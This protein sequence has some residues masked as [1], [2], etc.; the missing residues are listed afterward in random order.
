MKG[1]WNKIYMIEDGYFHRPCIKKGN[2]WDN[3]YYYL[4]LLNEVLKNHSLEMIYTTDEKFGL[5]EVKFVEPFE[6]SWED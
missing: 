6:Y 1:E 5:N 4:P 2:D 3:D